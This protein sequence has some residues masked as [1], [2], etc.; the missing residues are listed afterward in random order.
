MDY[1]AI[2]MARFEFIKAVSDLP[3]LLTGGVPLTVAR[4]VHPAHNPANSLQAV[5]LP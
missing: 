4:G 3:W 1:L 2:K 5:V